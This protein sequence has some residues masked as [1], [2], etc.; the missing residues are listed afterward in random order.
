MPKSKTRK[1]KNTRPSYRQ[2]PRASTTSTVAPSQALYL[3]L[4][5]PAW[6]MSEVVA[7]IQQVVPSLTKEVLLEMLLSHPLQIRDAEG[8]ENT[9]TP[10]QLVGNDQ[11]SA[12]EVLASMEVI[13]ELGFLAW[14]ATTRTHQMTEPTHA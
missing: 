3:P 13:H 6:Q 12:S 2:D 9:I 5:Y 11:A 1:T 10:L 7:T 14:D 8:Q 4:P